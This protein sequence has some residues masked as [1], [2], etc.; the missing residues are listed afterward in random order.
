MTGGLLVADAVG[1]FFVENQNQTSQ[2][3]LVDLL[4]ADAVGSFLVKTNFTVV[5]GGLLV[6]DAVGSFLVKTNFTVVTGG[7]LV[8]DA[9]GII[10]GKN[11]QTPQWWLVAD[12]V[13]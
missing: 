12:A 7:L 9:S 13:G 3:W 4:V 6:A 10:S 11:K 1:S 2:W 5:T 8:A